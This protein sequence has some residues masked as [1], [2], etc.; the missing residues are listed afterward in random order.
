MLLL[1]MALV[2]LPRADA[3]TTYQ[4]RGTNPPYSI[5]LEF[6]ESSDVAFN[7][8]VRQLIDRKLAW[9]H[10]TL[11]DWRPALPVDSTL[12]S[13]YD[14][15]KVNEI[16]S[17][18]LKFEWYLAGSAHPAH[19]LVCLN[20]DQRD[21]KVLKLAGLFHPGTNY[22]AFLSQFA[23]ADLNRQLQQGTYFSRPEMIEKGTGP[24]PQNFQCFTLTP[25]ALVLHF[26]E[27]QVGPYVSGPAKVTVP[28]AAIRSFFRLP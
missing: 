20:F 18:L 6:P 22:I 14:L 15:V 2:F 7:A 23:R 10:D 16:Q 19:E 12:T 9:F 17:L 27:Y 13:Q 25:N 26:Q 5:R 21:E 11:R 1:V 4:E 3:A 24:K 28:F 8:A